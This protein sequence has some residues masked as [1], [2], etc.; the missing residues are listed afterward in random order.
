LVENRYFHI[1]PS[2]GIG[3]VELSVSLDT[4]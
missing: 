1:L 2:L 3:Q 4:L